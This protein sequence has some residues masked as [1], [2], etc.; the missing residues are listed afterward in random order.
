MT[1]TVAKGKYALS[2][3]A[4]RD[5]FQADAVTSVL[6]YFAN[7]VDRCQGYAPTGSGKTHIAA[8]VWDG[9]EPEGSI[10]VL[11]SPTRAVSQAAGKFRDYCRATVPAA[12]TLQVTSGQGGT[13]DLARI[14]AFLADT[15]SPR[16]VFVTDSSLPR[17]TEALGNLGLMADL[18]I[19]DEAHRNTAVRQADVRAFWAEEAVADMHA[20]RRLYMTAT[21]RSSLDTAD[22]DGRALKVISQDN[23]DLF[24]PVAFDLS[25]DEAVAR[26]IVLPVA[27]YTFDTTDGELA[28]TF[29]RPGIDQI[30]HGARMD[31]REI[32]AHLA[33]YK[34]VTAGLPPADGTDG[35][36][37]RPER[38]MVSFS[39]VAQAKAFVRH[40]ADIMSAL[41]IP[42]AKAFLYVGATPEPGREEVRSSVR[43]LTYA[44]RR[45]SH[46]VIAQC[47]A[48]TEGFDLPDLDMTLLAA[49]GSSTIAVQQVIGRV[50]RL[51]VRSSKRWASVVT[52]DVN[53]DEGPASRRFTL[54]Y[55]RCRA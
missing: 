18:F 6:K 33:I 55:A 43:D 1:D 49:Y 5:A 23:A 42:A 16:M 32:A 44:R 53:P 52:T 28:E 12:R 27:A 37:Y 8:A 41:G 7:G 25:F 48:L 17:V 13:T 40:H 2:G 39:R 11:V 9:L 35:Q 50:T 26:G 51:P 20:A 45:L 47:G 38:I 10:L 36:P 54:S 19:V 30:W 3:N 14:E 31:C 4:E 15:T 46:A 22:G 29:G 24:G 21:P 34:A